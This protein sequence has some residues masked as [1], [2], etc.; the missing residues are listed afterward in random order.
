[1][2]PC[3]RLGEVGGGGGGWWRWV[4]VLAAVCIA[5]TSTT[6]TTSPNLHAPPARSEPAHHLGQLFHDVQLSGLFEDSKTFADA[7]PR[8]APAEIPPRYGPARGPPQLH[9]GAF[10]GGPFR[11]PPPAALRFRR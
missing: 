10:V 2:R 9:P 4:H 3:G 8:L 5:T 6:C 7:R 11:P 1:M